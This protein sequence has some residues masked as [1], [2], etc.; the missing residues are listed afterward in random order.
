MPG[1]G[2]IQALQ[3]T[4]IHHRIARERPYPFQDCVEREKHGQSQYNPMG[5]TCPEAEDG[6]THT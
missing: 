3:C 2:T 6:V 5:R 1:I 4:F